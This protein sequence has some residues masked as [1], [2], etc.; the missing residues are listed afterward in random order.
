MGDDI[1]DSEVEGVATIDADLTEY[2][3]NE[4]DHVSVFLEMHQLSGFT[5]TLQLVVLKFNQEK[6]INKV[7]TCAYTIVARVN[8]SSVATP[9]LISYSGKKLVGYCSTHWSSTYCISS[10]INRGY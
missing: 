1:D 9:K 10:I 2:E 3:E 5:H 4:Q 8:A 7:V 6:S